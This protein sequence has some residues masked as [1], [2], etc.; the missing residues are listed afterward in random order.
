MEKSAEQA[1]HLPPK[2]L[3]TIFDVDRP[4]RFA[5]RARLA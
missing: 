2:L 5:A 3:A 1:Q 4:R